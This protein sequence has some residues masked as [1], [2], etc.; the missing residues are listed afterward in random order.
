[1]YKMGKTVKEIETIAKSLNAN[2]IS[3]MTGAD[4]AK[5]LQSNGFTR[6]D[7][8]LVRTMVCKNK[9]GGK[10]NKTRNHRKRKNKTQRG[11]VTQNE[12]EILETFI[13]V[14]ILYGLYCILT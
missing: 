1:M 12:Q 8:Q 3:G 7:I 11:G 4:L 6:E 5:M 9:I 2:E 13:Y 10:K 14:A